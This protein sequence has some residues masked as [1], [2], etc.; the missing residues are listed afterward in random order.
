MVIL[1]SRVVVLLDLNELGRQGLSLGS[2]ADGLAGDR[3]P[4]EL[5]PILHNEQYS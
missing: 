1:L 3:I 4:L 5:S 2:R